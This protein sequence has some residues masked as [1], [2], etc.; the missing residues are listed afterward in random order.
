MNGFAGGLGWWL[1]ILGSLAPIFTVLIAAIGVVL[2]LRTLKL[3]SKV[4][5]AGQWWV[6]VQYAMDR[7]L[8][9]DL[10]EQNVGITMLDYLQGQSDPPEQLDEEQRE[11]WLRAHKDSWRVQPE[12]L[13]LIHEMVKELALGK[14]AK[15]AAAGIRAEHEHDREYDTLLRQA[16]LVQKLEAKL[17]IAQDPEIS[18]ILA[19]G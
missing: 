4:D 16:K 12:D 7:C 15:L 19:Q 1:A 8:S 11:A 2:A 18:R 14:S 5:I 9:P 6:R 13:A 17:G 3:R 10:T